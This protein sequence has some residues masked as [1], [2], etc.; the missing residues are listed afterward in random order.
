MPGEESMLDALMLAAG[1]AFF[2]IAMAYVT[3]C[4]RM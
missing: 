3:A 2:A 1:V 4:D